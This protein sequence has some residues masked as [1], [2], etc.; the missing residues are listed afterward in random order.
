MT[1]HP[2]DDFHAEQ[3]QS[4]PDPLPAH[5]PEPASRTRYCGYH[6]CGQ[7]LAYDGRGRPPEYC[8][9]RRWPGGRTCR[10]MAAAERAAERA[11]GLATPLDTFRAL[12]DRLADTAAPLVRQLT[13]LLDAVTQVRD[14]ALARMQE[15]R[16]AE[17]AAEQ[18]A[19]EACEAAE[20]AEQARRAA[21]A[22]RDAALAQAETA[23]AQAKFSRASRQRTS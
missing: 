7:P 11:A 15:A 22:D 6:A 19:R 2:V 9:D 1:H 3:P 5:Q 4:T 12:S 20:R 18:R 21:E 16:Q 14:D 8:P 17:A 23:L 10:Q 13:E